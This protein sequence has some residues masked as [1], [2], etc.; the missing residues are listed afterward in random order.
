MDT[1]DKGMSHDL[2]RMEDSMSFHHATQNCH[3]SSMMKLRQHSMPSKTY[4]L[5]IPGIF[6]LE[7]WVH[8][9]RMKPWKTR[10]Q[11]KGDYYKYF[12]NIKA[13]STLAGW[14][15]GSI[16]LYTKRLRGLI[17]G[18]GV[19]KSQLIDVSLS[20]SLSFLSKIS[21]IYSQVRI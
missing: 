3:L 16:I 9:S 20:L 2:G 7:L 19:Y 4:E 12:W 21:K 13:R 5:F 6:H 18:Q 10:P 15:N 17:P 8:S 1:L 14:L 11:I